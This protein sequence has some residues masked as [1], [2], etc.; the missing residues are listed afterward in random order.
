MSLLGK[1]IKTVIEVIELPV[2]VIKDAATLGGELTERNQ[3][4][5]SE[6]I[7][8]IRDDWNE[9]KDGL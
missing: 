5:T 1:L 8:D 3:S 4:Y 7:N 9:F 2:S 6:K